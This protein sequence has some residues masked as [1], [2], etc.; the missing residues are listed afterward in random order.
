M[1]L[2][3]QQLQALRERMG[4]VYGG[5]RASD[6]AK[7][8]YRVRLSRWHYCSKIVETLL[9]PQVPAGVLP[10][11]GHSDESFINANHSAEGT[12]GLTEKAWEEAV[13]T[14]LVE[15]AQQGEDIAQAHVSLA[16]LADGAGG[17][18]LVRVDKPKSGKGAGCTCY[19]RRR[20]KHTAGRRKARCRWRPRP[21]ARRSASEL[22]D[23]EQTNRP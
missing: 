21:P 14:E 18:N 13:V 17:K 3:R 20:V 1:V 11:E 4:L 23:A 7:E 9:H 10:I 19:P 12:Y 8:S 22:R 16:G 6:G 2:G 5:K 15:R